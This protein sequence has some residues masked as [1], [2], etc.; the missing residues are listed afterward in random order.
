MDKSLLENYVQKL[1]KYTNTKLSLVYIDDPTTIKSYHLLT[2]II[3]KNLVGSCYKI[4]F[5]DVSISS[6]ICYGFT[7]DF[8][9]S[10]AID[11]ESI[12]RIDLLTSDLY[13]ALYGDFN[14]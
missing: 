3:T 12:R 8:D 11:I 14:D 6:P 7:E 1:Q 5:K 10:M 4:M 2:R 9:T 13:K